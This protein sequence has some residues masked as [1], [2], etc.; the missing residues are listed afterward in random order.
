M[1]FLFSYL[2]ID[3]LDQKINVIDLQEV[4]K[5]SDFGYLT[6]IYLKLKLGYQ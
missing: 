1:F 4:L 2:V 6:H 3:A 5:L